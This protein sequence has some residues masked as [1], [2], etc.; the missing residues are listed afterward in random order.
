VWKR[1]FLFDFGKTVQK[2]VM[3]RKKKLKNYGL[4]NNFYFKMLIGKHFYYFNLSIC[5]F[6]KNL[7]RKSFGS[8]ILVEAKRGNIAVRINGN[9]IARY[10]TIAP[11]KG[12]V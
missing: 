7:L 10:L 9:A 3:R 6:K 11:E 8:L 2:Y 1:K 4:I 12:M 5:S